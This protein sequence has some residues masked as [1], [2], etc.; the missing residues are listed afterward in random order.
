MDHCNGFPTPT[1]FDADLGTYVN[2]S[3]AKRD[4]PNSYA[5]VIGMMPYPESNKRS[6]ISFYAHQCFRFTHNIRASHE[7]DVRRTCQYLQGAKYK[8][9]IF[10]AYNKLVVYCYA[11]ADFAGLW[12]NENPQG[13]ICA[14]S[15]T[16]FLVTFA[17]F[18]LV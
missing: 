17:N 8:G 3:E 15:R 18:H 13:P 10:N 12:G 16:A 1:K 5:S 4:L 6:Y 7:T 9:L 14:R 2:G 11:D